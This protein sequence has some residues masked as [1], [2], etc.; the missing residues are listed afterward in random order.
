MA[1]AVDHGER[2]L[3]QGSSN[4]PAVA[5]TEGRRIVAAIEELSAELGSREGPSAQ[6]RRWAAAGTRSPGDLD[7]GDEELIARLRAAL[8]TLAGAA[9]AGEDGRK[10][11]ERAVIAALDGAELVMRGEILLGNG[12]RISG[13]VPS[14]AFLAT[15]PMTGKERAL[16]ISRRA[17]ELLE[18]AE[19]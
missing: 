12:E 14:F 5:G 15:L 1:R 17:T 9:R 10:D 7:A 19:T 3:P 16:A 8:A 4:L 13:L 6:S 18:E 2:T 11:S